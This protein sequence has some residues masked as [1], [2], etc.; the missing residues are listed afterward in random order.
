VL[1][2]GVIV[3]GAEIARLLADQGAEVIK[4]E[5]QANPDG[6]RVSPE[7]FAIGH[8]GSRSIGLDLR[9]PE[10]KHMFKQLVA[11]SDVVLSNFKPGTLEKLGLGYDELR[12]IN[13]RLIMVSSS[14]VGATGP[15]SSWMGYGPLVRCATG[16]T[17]L[18]RYPDEPDSFSDGTTIYPDHFAARV[19]AVAV[20][21]ALIARTR[22][23]CG[24][25][26]R[27][28]QA[29]SILM[30][31]SDLIAAESVAPDTVQVH[32]N[33]RPDAAPWNVYPCA[34]DDEWCVITVRDDSDWRLRSALGDPRW[35]RDPA[36]TTTAGR[37]ASRAEIDAQL[38]A[39]TTGYTPRQV[40]ERLQAVGVPA[41]FMQRV[42]EHED[43]PHFAARDFLVPMEQPGMDARLVENGPFRATHVPEPE[44]RPAPGMGEHTREI[45]TELL[46]LDAE[47]IDALLGQG[48]LQETAAPEPIAG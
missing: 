27:S 35:A 8:R 42:G 5:S 34:G 21:A 38:A 6:A 47:Q 32:G 14:A 18:W 19:E 3:M 24:V 12:A 40:T 2:L 4:I 30:M 29:E 33:T 45:A 17:S 44:I 28:S 15:W 48:V 20:L 23:G 37:V 39:W 1:D 25:H 43:D 9:S 41:G 11:D 31:L 10:G 16:T 22:T 7:H 26:I 36:Y 46:G 13:D